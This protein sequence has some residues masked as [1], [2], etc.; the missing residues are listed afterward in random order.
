MLQLIRLYL[1]TEIH[2]KMLHLLLPG[3]KIVT[4]FILLYGNKIYF[5]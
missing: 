5:E 3:Y 2:S 4:A 1:E